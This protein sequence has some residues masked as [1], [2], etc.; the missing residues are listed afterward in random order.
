MDIRRAKQ[1]FDS[2]KEV[3]VHYQGKPVWI[4][5][6]D[7]SSQTARIYPLDNPDNEMT[8]SVHQLEEV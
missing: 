2:T 8:V 5:N 3:E 4:Q 1:I 7:E 6:V